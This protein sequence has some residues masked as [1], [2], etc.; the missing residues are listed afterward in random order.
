V[1]DY[2]ADIVAEC[3]IWKHGVPNCIIH[4]WAVEFLS[5]AHQRGLEQFPTSG[6]YPQ[7][8]GLVE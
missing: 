1:R 3:L 4:Y 8:D 2:R 5:E 7:T 6:G